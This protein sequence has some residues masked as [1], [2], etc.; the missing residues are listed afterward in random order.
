MKR[1]LFLLTLF[2]IHLTF[3]SQKELTLKEAV[4]APRIGL[5]PKNVNQLN[6]LEGV[7][8][9]RYTTDN[10]IIVKTP[11]KCSVD[12]ILY[13]DSLYGTNGKI[14]NIIY[15]DNKKLIYQIKDKIVEKQF[16]ATDRYID[17]N[18][19]IYNL[20]DKSANYK[21]YVDSTF[22]IAYTIDN[23]VYFLDE[24]K[25]QIQITS[26]DDKNIVSGQAIHRYEFGISEGLFWSPDG[27]KL[28][29][30]Q[31]DETDVANYPLLNVNETPGELKLIKY[32]MAGQKSEYAKVGVYDLEK[33]TIKYLK[34][35]GAKDSYLT[36]LTWGP[37]SNKIYIAHVNREQNQMYWIQYSAN[38]SKMLETLI[39][40]EN[41]TWVEPEYPIFFNPVNDSQFMY[42]SEKSGYMAAYLF[43]IPDKTHTLITKLNEIR[44]RRVG[45]TTFFEEFYFP[46][47][48]VKGFSDDGK[49]FYFTAT[50]AD[51]KNNLGFRVEVSTGKKQLLTTSEGVHNI[52]ISSSGNY[53]TDSYSVQGKPR[54]VDI[55]EVN[56]KKKNRINIFKAD[57]PLNKYNLGETEFVKFF[58][59]DSFELHGRIIYPHNFIDSSEKKYPV[60]VYVYGGPHAQLVK[61][62]WLGGASL[63]MHWMANQG[64]IVF[65]VDGRGSANRGF[66]FES[67]IHRELGKKEME[68]QIMGINFLKRQNFVDSTRIAV[69]G[70]SFGGFMTTSLML[71]YPNVF[72]TGVAG[73]PVMDW[74]W[75]EV[76]YG[77]RYMD[78]PEENPE[79]YKNS[80]TLNNVSKLRG[81]LMTIHGTVDDVVVMQHNLAFIQECIK[82]GVQVDFFPYP[83][84]PHNVRGKDRVHLMTKV[85]NYILE[86]NK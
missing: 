10:T 24:N 47:T 39:F 82:K 35:Y 7:D 67:V 85:L 48:G 45:T 69:H 16:R 28:A 46:I 68:D 18:T 75:Y 79:G 49:Y 66:D 61:N 11:D 4:L 25:Q 62:N 40:E 14:P 21:Y 30:Y 54:V 56:K 78:A 12:I 60:L 5:Y 80:S 51:P 22:K 9:Y 81:K 41:S 3:H 44:T 55:V 52:K 64:Y 27:K 23:N 50:G 13:A 83:M 77:E 72:T 34:T 86:N 6:W 84:H 29:F 32:P 65:T 17:S 36:N 63:W 26:F 2:S 70:W 33:K 37:N 74:K 8:K 53:I 76:M 59:K 15:M 57:N 38:S 71:K 73:G 42:L 19:T 43:D 31:K 58:S 20:P 1:N